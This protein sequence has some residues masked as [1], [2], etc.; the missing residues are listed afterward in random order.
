MVAMSLENL[1]ITGGNNGNLEKQ[2]PGIGRQVS[3]CSGVEDQRIAPI[4]S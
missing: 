1:N 3:D 4:S 2:G